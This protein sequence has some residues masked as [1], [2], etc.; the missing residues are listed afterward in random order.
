MHEWWGRLGFGFR[1]GVWVWVWLRFWLG[2]R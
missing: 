2:L 1:I